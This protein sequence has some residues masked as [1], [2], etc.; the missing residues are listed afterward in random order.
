MIGFTY[1]TVTG[2]KSCHFL[3]LNV[4]NMCL[5]S[6]C[7]KIRAHCCSFPPAFIRLTFYF[8]NIKYSL[9]FNRENSTK[10]KKWSKDLNEK[11]HSV[12]S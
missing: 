6:Q 5:A 11:Y 4:I 2:C 8:Y 9:V 12:K 10:V 1:D 7:G 3:Y